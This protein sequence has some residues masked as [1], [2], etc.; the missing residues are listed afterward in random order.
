[1]TGIF[2]RGTRA[3]AIAALMGTSAFAT[4]QATEWNQLQDSAW[5]KEQTQANSQAS[6]SGG[7]A[8]TASSSASGAGDAGTEIATAFENLGMEQARAECYGKVLT[9]KLSPDDQQNAAQLVRSASNGDEVRSAVLD[10]GP[11][12]VGGFSA[13][14]TTCPEGMGG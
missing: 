6:A 11:N 8:P 4:A 10:A 2:R 9:E 14:D 3:L 13:A 12:M 5:N 7:S 1:M